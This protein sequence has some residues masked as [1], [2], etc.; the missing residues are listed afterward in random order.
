MADIVT[1]RFWATRD[2]IAV[3]VLACPTCQ[4]RMKLLALVKGPESIACY[5]ATVGEATE[6]PRRGSR[7]GRASF[8]RLLIHPVLQSWQ[9]RLTFT[10]ALIPRHSESDPWSACMIMPLHFRYRG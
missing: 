9:T 2:G 1:Q 5:L 3:D 4:G 10:L 8:S 6:V 7:R